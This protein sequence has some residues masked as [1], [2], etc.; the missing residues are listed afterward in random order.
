[1]AASLLVVI[2]RR[3]VGGFLV[4]S[5]ELLQGWQRRGVADTSGCGVNFE[6]GNLVGLAVTLLTTAVSFYIY[7]MGVHYQD[8]TLSRWAAL[9]FFVSGAVGVWTLVRIL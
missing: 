1:M 5:Q 9:A 4:N 6:T 2:H 7:V 8:R 3:L